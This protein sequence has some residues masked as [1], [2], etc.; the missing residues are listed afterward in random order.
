MLQVKIIFRLNLF[1]M[2]LI[3]TFPYRLALI[4]ELL[5]LGD[6]GNRESIKIKKI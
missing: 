5:G 2:G 4:H 6:K 1:N 3:L